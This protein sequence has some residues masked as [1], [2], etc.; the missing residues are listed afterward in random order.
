VD[1]IHQALKP[2]RKLYAEPPTVLKACRQAMIDA[3][4]MRSAINRHVNRIRAAFKWAVENELVPPDV[5]HG[6]RVGHLTV[7]PES[8]RQREPQP[9]QQFRLLRSGSRDT[10]EPQRP[11]LHSN[12]Q[13]VP[14]LHVMQNP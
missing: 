9:G 3:G 14:D 4:H 5:L 12:Q 6:L 13:N 8:L 10:A 7:R 11:A 2:V 1:W